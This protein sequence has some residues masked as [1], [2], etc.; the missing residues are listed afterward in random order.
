MSKHSSDDD[1]TTECAICRGKSGSKSGKFV[2]CDECAR[3]Y[4]FECVGVGD[5]IAS[6]SFVCATCRIQTNVE[7]GQEA[8]AREEREKDFDKEKLQERESADRPGTSSAAQSK[9]A[10]SDPE[11][12]ELLLSDCEKLVERVKA[13]S[14]ELER[15]K[16]EKAAIVNERDELLKMVTELQSRASLPVPSAPHPEPQVVDAVT[17][18]LRKL[19]VEQDRLF[20]R[21]D[22]STPQRNSH[23]PPQHEAFNDSVSNSTLNLTNFEKLATVMNRAN[24]QK[25]PEFSG[26]IREWPFFESVFA[27]TTFEGFYSEEENV[28]RLRVAL[29]GDALKLVS[30]QVR[31][32]KSASSIMEELRL[33]FGRPDRLI[34]CLTSE[35]YNFPALKSQ[36]DPRLKDLAIRVKSFVADMKAMKCISELSNS[37]TLSVL[38]GKLKESHYRGWLKKKLADPEANIETF[39]KYLS[40]KVRELAPLLELKLDDAHQERNRPFNHRVLSH[41]HDHEQLRHDPKSCPLCSAETHS[42]DK[43]LEFRKLNV[44]ARYIFAKD[45]RICFHCLGPDDHVWIGCKKNGPCK[46]TGCNAYHHQLM[47]NPSR[48]P[49]PTIQAQRSQPQLTHTSA[50]P[51]IMFKILPVTLYGNNDKVIHTY[52][53]LDSGSSLSM[54][55][56]ETF[57]QLQL[58][59]NRHDLHLK[60]TK[61]VT[62]KEDSFRSSLQISGFDGK[63][64]R[65]SNISSVKDLQLPSQ[66][67]NAGELKERFP[68]LRGLPINDFQKAKPTILLGLDQ[69]E[70][71]EGSQL[72]RRAA[73][74]PFASKTLLGW[75][76]SG[77]VFPL[78][79]CRSAECLSFDE[80]TVSPSIKYKRD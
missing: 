61:G 80:N 68:Y 44:D 45:Y 74:E 78:K 54:I 42:I 57:D 39:A 34:L 40:E 24:I 62:R 27:A 5:S 75:V 52:A 76:L 2:E 70:F 65:L 1:G 48:R 72:V 43:C 18:R 50:T 33:E 64:H 46:I 47:H 51:P 53:Y 38:S 14:L 17:E 56:Q 12:V 16:L 22:H 8:F 20:G 63:R 4:H 26:E 21:S 49:V 30:D 28:A 9:P 23:R 55:E 58:S 15:E 6:K 25:L 67:L 36:D 31:F 32:S 29:K 77:Q 11:I 60:W 79:Q 59:G 37:V 10:Y 19:R 13:I 71:I 35:L 7:T 41:Q 69:C 73:N 66:S 3:W